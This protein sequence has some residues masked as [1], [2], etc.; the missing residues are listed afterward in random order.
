MADPT[1]KEIVLEEL[2]CLY[3]S[4]EKAGALIPLVK[5]WVDAAVE[6]TTLAHEPETEDWFTQKCRDPEF[7][8][9]YLEEQRKEAAED[10]RV[11]VE[12]RQE[13]SAKKC[14]AIAKAGEDLPITQDGMGAGNARICAAA[15][16]G[17]PSKNETSAPDPSPFGFAF[18]REALE[19]HLP[20]EDGAVGGCDMCLA[21]DVT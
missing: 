17:G 18:L 11:A 8:K 20:C 19:T 14:D 7:V 6:A 1:P 10:L 13:W 15:I 9:A 21:L 12:D 16:R 5:A 2:L 4:D 3:I